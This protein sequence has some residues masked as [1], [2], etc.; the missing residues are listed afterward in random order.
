MAQRI[1]TFLASLAREDDPRSKGKGLTGPSLGGLWRY[2]VGDWRIVVDI[3]QAELVI[4]ALDIGH[5]SR[6]CR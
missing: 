3:H 1:T 4:L 5:R 2:R 6:V